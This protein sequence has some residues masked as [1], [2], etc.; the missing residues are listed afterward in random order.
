MDELYE[1]YKCIAANEKQVFH[2]KQ[3]SIISLLIFACQHIDT[4]FS[5][6]L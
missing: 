3:A 4:G 5:L 1:Q 2:D 6:F